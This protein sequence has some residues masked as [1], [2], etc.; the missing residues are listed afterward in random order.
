ME[1]KEI[2][3]SLG[4]NCR[5]D[6]DYLRCRPIYR[7]SDND[8]SLRVSKK[9]GYANDYGIGSSFSLGELIK[10]TLGLKD[11]KEAYTYL[12]SNFQFRPNLIK[13]KPKIH[14]APKFDQSFV[15]SL[16][17][18]H[19]YW[20]GRGISKEIIEQ[21]GGGVD[22]KGNRYW[23]PVLDSQKNVIGLTGRALRPENKVKW[24]HKGTK[25]L[26]VWPMFLNLKDIQEKQ[27]VILVESIGNGL[28]LHECGIKN[29]LVCFGTEVSNSLLTSLIKLNL[30]KIIIT[31]DNDTVNNN[32]SIG[33]NAA[34]KAYSR[35]IRYFD[36]RQLKIATPPNHND[37]NE[38]LTKGNKHEIIDFYDHS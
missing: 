26:W 11:I 38:W 13:D 7:D 34:K 35:L 8:N 5:D 27:E 16:K 15:S 1:V 3:E 21:F 22:E 36:S 32:N 20:L 6:G 17:K 10:V 33:E 31:F 4:Y 25:S 14:L 19:S 37:L 18:D 2:L 23:F 28:S 9:T 30:K 12:E 29:Y 24:L